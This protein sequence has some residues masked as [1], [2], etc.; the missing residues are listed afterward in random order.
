[1]KKGTDCGGPGENGGPGVPLNPEFKAFRESGLCKDS[2]HSIF[3][4]Q[5]KGQR[6]A[7]SRASGGPWNQI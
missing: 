1:M 6:A 2:F 4:F 3:P 7:R 5:V